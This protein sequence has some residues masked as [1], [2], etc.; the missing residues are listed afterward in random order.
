M[1]ALKIFLTVLLVFS[2]IGQF[3]PSQRREVLNFK[4]FWVVQWWIRLALKLGAVIA[5]W[6][7]L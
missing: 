1:L 6:V 5:V 3:P 7:M 2:A 4:T